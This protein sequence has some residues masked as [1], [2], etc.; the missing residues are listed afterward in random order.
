MSARLEKNLT[1]AV[2][3]P[4]FHQKH[5]DTLFWAN[6]RSKKKA[7]ALDSSSYLCMCVL[8]P[9]VDSG[10]FLRYSLP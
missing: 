3:I 10:V 8:L 4:S 2:S 6:S 9:D 7:V 5:K 1:L